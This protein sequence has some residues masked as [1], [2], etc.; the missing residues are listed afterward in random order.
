MPQPLKH[1]AA[2]AMRIEPLD[3]RLCLSVTPVFDAG[4]LKVTGTPEADAF[5]IVDTGRGVVRVED[6]DSGDTW[7]F[8]EVRQIIAD[9]LAGDD[10]VRF[11]RDSGAA[12]LPM[13]QIRLG[14]GADSLRVS[15]NLGGPAVT[16]PAAPT[17][18][19]R[20]MSLS[21]SGGDGNDDVGIGLYA[22]PLLNSHATAARVNVALGGGDDQFN[23]HRSGVDNVG[24][25]LTAGAGD[26]SVSIGMLL[27]AVQ[28]VREAAARMKINLGEGNNHFRLNTAVD[29]TELDLTAGE[30]NDSVLIGM[31]LPA[32]QKVREAAARMKVDL[33]GGGDRFQLNGPAVDQLDLD[34]STGDGADRVL[35]GMLLPAVQKVR[36]AAARMNVDLG[37]GDDRFD[38][39]VAGL[40]QLD[41]K[42][43]AGEGND[44]ISAGLTTVQPVA[45]ILPPPTPVPGSAAR[46]NVELGAG[47][48]QFQLR[49]TG[50]HNV[51]LDLSAGEGDD[52][53]L[54][55]ML[56][57][58]VQK[59]REAA[60]RMNVD[61]GAGNDR[62]RV[63]ETGYTT[64]G[65]SVLAGA[66]D[67]DIGIGLLLPAVQK[68]NGSVARVKVDLG[69]GKDHLTMRIH[70]YETVETEIIDEDDEDDVIDV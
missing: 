38:L 34:L 65:L 64:V 19:V 2:R 10:K 48:D 7:E 35:I 66:G 30:G 49:S 5:A 51:G 36:E 3:Q 54:I 62:L 63:S 27:P 28:K 44:T 60:A 59:V 42:L 53:V 69:P 33:G 15:A 40:D 50:V 41:L 17:P 21:V 52:N 31:L 55:G 57:P 18:I 56:L 39:S 1:R 37:G 70:G 58:A 47:N 68:V 13:V 25:G 20:Q 22:H 46:L 67:D 16:D 11:A 32:V 61:L 12:A 24:L 45:A 6:L 8:R 23:L 4:I 14:E 26:D 9:A 43:A 29:K